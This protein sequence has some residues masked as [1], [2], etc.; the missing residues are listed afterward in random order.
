[1]KEGETVR[2]EKRK[3][4]R[5][6]ECRY[7]L[8]RISRQEGLSHQWKVSGRYKRMYLSLS[9]IARVKDDR[10]IHA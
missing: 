8:F 9:Q 5:Q 2:E 10:D 6:E 3:N 4:A 7:N 1:M